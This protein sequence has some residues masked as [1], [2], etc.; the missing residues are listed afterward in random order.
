MQEPF[1]R[2]PNLVLTK[3]M[4]I[5][6]YAGNFQNTAELVQ[7][8]AKKFQHFFSG[9]IWPPLVWTFWDQTIRKLTHQCSMLVG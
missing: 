8:E 3:K 2:I 9:F 7:L 6:T 5:G 4:V 1:T